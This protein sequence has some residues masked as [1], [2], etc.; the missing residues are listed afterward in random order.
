MSDKKADMEYTGQRIIWDTKSFL[1]TSG[2]RD[3]AGSFSYQSS[4]FQC[5]KPTE[6]DEDKAGPIPEGTYRFSLVIDTR[7]ARDY[8]KAS[9]T[10]KR[11][12]YNR[13]QEIPLKRY[14]GYCEDYWLNWGWNRVPLIPDDQ[15]T[16]KIC[17]GK[18]GSFYLHDSGK[19]YTHGCIEVENRFFKELY[20]YIL[21]HPKT[22]MLKLRVKYSDPRKTSTYGFSDTEDHSKKFVIRQGRYIKP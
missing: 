22:K 13:I 11:D 16:R 18:R 4:D 5:L 21:K 9:C 15:V 14:S 6:R 12:K 2:M 20:S 7:M 10:L 17:G 8:G 1:A 19:G 3:P